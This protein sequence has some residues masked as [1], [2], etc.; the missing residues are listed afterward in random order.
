MTG[1][2]GYLGS[3][4]MHSYQKKFLFDTFSIRTQKM[5]DIAF[6]GVDIVVHCAALVHQKREE[7]YEKYHEINVEYPLNLA[8]LAKKSGVKQFVFLST[9]AVYGEDKERVDEQTPCSP[10]TPYGISKLEAEKQLLVL[11]D[12]GFVVSI[13]RSPMVYGKDAPGNMERLV[14]LVKK[15]SLLPFGGIDNKRAFVFIEN[16]C[17]FIDAVIELHLKHGTRACRVFLAS[18]DESLS[19]TRLIELIAHKLEKKIF[20]FQIPFFEIFLKR[21]KP[22]VYQRLY[23]SLEIDNTRSKKRLFGDAKASLPYTVQE[24]ISLMIKGDVK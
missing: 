9:I 13:I 5:E 10:V 6:D 16:L 4:F 21:L 23:K 12:D 7:S 3:S 18:D 15:V 19:T 2:S 8:K 1:S 22:S 20:L 17:S 11:N 14:Q 24:G